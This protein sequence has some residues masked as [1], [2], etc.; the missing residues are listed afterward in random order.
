MVL[1]V[2]EIEN[3]CTS[4]QKKPLHK[5]LSLKLYQG[6]VLGLVGASGSGKSILLRT[7]LGLT[8]YDSGSIRIFNIDNRD[9]T[10]LNLLQRRW[11]VLFQNGALFSSLTVGENIRVPM[12]EIAKVPESL[13]RELTFL[14]LSLVGLPKEAE[15]KFP[16]ELSGG[17]VKRAALARALAID[18][19]LLFLDEPTSGLDPISARN[20]DLLI[21][22]LQQNLNLTVMM[23]THDLDSL[24][25]VCNRVA[26]LVDQKL[27]IGTALS[28]QKHPHPW[29]KDYFRGRMTS[30]PIKEN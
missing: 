8:R 22:E 3:L 2:L 6:E 7:I 27:I 14:K 12:R 5:N 18:A 25:T 20:F 16:S 23:I 24:F 4:I 11:G 13:A 29:I 1:S 26:V 9:Q 15:S 30:A 28:L 19:E 17:M 21:K 10:S